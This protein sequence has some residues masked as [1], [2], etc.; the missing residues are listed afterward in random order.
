MAKNWHQFSAR[1]HKEFLEENGFYYARTHG[2]HEFYVKRNLPDKVVQ[3]VVSNKEN[4]RQS[5]KTMDMSSR[6]S[7]MPKS[8]YKKWINLLS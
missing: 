2:S 5:R 8:E 7:G 3:V 6:H 4:H 1:E